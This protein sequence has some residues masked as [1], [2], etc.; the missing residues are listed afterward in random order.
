MQ[1][2]KGKKSS[3]DNIY[4]KLG[5]MGQGF[6]S[7]PPSVFPVPPSPRQGTPTSGRKQQQNGLLQTLSKVEQQSEKRAY[8][9]I[10]LRTLVLRLEKEREDALATAKHVKEE[11]AELRE[12]L[13]HVQSELAILHKEQ[14]RMRVNGW[15]D[16]ASGLSTVRAAAA[17][18]AGGGGEGLASAN[19]PSAAAPADAEKEEEGT[20]VHAA[21]AGG[22][23]VQLTKT[24]SL[25]TEGALEALNSAPPAAAAAGGVSIPPSPAGAI[26]ASPQ[27][28][29]SVAGAASEAGLVSG[30]SSPKLGTQNSKGAAAIKSEAEHSVKTH[31]LD[32]DVD[33]LQQ[34]VRQLQAEL[35]Q[36]KAVQQQAIRDKAAAESR[37]KELRLELEGLENE[38]IAAAATSS[39]TLGRS[40]TGPSGARNAPSIS[41]MAFLH[42]SDTEALEKLREDM[43]KMVEDKDSV[44]QLRQVEID[45]LKYQHTL[46]NKEKD[47]HLQKLLGDNDGLRRKAQEMELKVEQL[48]KQITELQSVADRAVA[49]AAKAKAKLSSTEQQGSGFAGGKGYKSSG[50][51]EKMASAAA[52]ALGNDDITAAAAAAIVQDSAPAPAPDPDGIAEDL[53]G[54]KVEL[55]EQIVRQSQ[56][57]QE[58]L[59]QQH[60]EEI[61]KLTADLESAGNGKV[62]ATKAAE[63][64]QAQIASMETGSAELK[65]RIQ[66]LQ[67]LLEEA[68]KER[69]AAAAKVTE[70][71]GRAE[72][73]A[74]SASA[75]AAVLE[76]R[77]SESAGQVQELQY[78]LEASEDRIKSLE[79]QL[80]DKAIQIRSS[81]DP[82]L[83]LHAEDV[84]TSDPRPENSN[85]SPESL[86]VIPEAPPLIS[87]AFPDTA[88]TPQE[89]TEDPPPEAVPDSTQEPPG[90]TSA[91]P[92]EDKVS[93]DELQVQILALTTQVASLKEALSQAEAAASSAHAEAA[94]AISAKSG[95]QASLEASMA[96]AE[97]AQAAAG[98]VAVKVEEAESKLAAAVLAAE[99]AAVKAAEEKAA[100]DA[101]AVQATEDAEL[102]LLEL[103]QS[104]EALEKL[105]MELSAQVA[106]FDLLTLQV[107]ELRAENNLL[108]EQSESVA[109][110]WRKKLE[111]AAAEA[112]LE[113]EILAKKEAEL[114]DSNENLDLLRTMYANKTEELEEVKLQ[115][116]SRS[117][118][119]AIVKEE[120]ARLAVQLSAL[121]MVHTE[122]ELQQ[123]QHTAA[124][125]GAEGKLR[126]LEQ[127][128]LATVAAAAA[129]L[130]EAHAE[131]ERLEQNL[132]L[133]ENLRQAAEERIRV[134]SDR[135]KAEAE[136]ARKAAAKELKSVKDMAAQEARHAA[137]SFE[138]LS[139]QNKK[140]KALIKTMASQLETQQ[141]TMAAQAAA[142]AKHVEALGEARHQTLDMERKWKDSDKLL[143]DRLED[144]ERKLTGYRLRLSSQQKE[145]TARSASTPSQMGSRGEMQRVFRKL[146]IIT[147]MYNLNVGPTLAS[148]MTSD[149]ANSATEL[150]MWQAVHA[151]M[152]ALESQAAAAG[153]GSTWAG[154]YSVVS[155]SRPTT[156][157]SNIRPFS[158]PSPG[159]SLMGSPVS[160]PAAVAESSG[161]GNINAWASTSPLSS[162][163]DVKLLPPPFVTSHKPP[164]VATDYQAS[165]PAPAAAAAQQSPRGNVSA[166]R[167][168]QP[169]RG[170]SEAGSDAMSLLAGH[171]TTKSTTSNHLTSS[172]RADA[173]SRPVSAAVS[174]TDPLCMS[175]ELLSTHDES[176]THAAGAPSRTPSMQVSS[177]PPETTYNM[178]PSDTEPSG[179]IAKTPL[180]LTPL[181][182][183]A[184]SN[185]P[186]LKA[187]VCAVEE[188]EVPAPV[189]EAVVPA[190][191]EEAEVPAAVEEAEVPAPVEKGSPPTAFSYN[192]PDLQ[193][194]A[195]APQLEVKLSSAEV[196][197]PQLEV[198]LSSA[199]ITEDGDS[200]ATT[201]MAS[202]KESVVEDTQVS[203]AVEASVII[204]E[205]GLEVGSGPRGTEVLRTTTDM[206]GGNVHRV[207]DD[208]TPGGEG[209]A[210]MPVEAFLEQNLEAPTASDPATVARL[211]SAAPS[212]C[213]VSHLLPDIQEEELGADTEKESSP[214]T[215]IA[216]D[217]LENDGRGESTPNVQEAAV[218]ASE[219]DEASSLLQQAR[220]HNSADNV[221]GAGEIVGSS[222]GSN[223]KSATPD[224]A[225]AVADTMTLQDSSQSGNDSSR[226]H[227]LQDELSHKLPVMGMTSRP[228]SAVHQDRVVAVAGSRPSSAKLQSRP[229]SARGLVPS[230]S[231]ARREGELPAASVVVPSIPSEGLGQG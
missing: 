126:L 75:A 231:L 115:L 54:R 63:A 106:Q 49:A 175:D 24:A 92:L 64:F 97:A 72:A 213:V 11:N 183:I 129:K 128:R 6:P 201:E 221:A 203:G 224:V 164:K 225:E 16:N 181:S 153:A 34:A 93:M 177:Y 42:P 81:A 21:G 185:I 7:M 200:Q 47:E 218:N 73:V 154:S 18:S 38:K 219:S 50:K 136:R 87:G 111:D 170:S 147:M 151:V 40:K 45:H 130:A 96:G 56:E 211:Q 204:Q 139:L 186:G 156:S 198:K 137:E 95:L 202:V 174:S 113:A 195:P 66:E 107:A 135:V 215:T 190:L 14:T 159:R 167:L 26:P 15:L 134:Y 61:R 104:K 199:D 223:K 131:N 222:D 37:S 108:K 149:S 100:A 85:A 33:Q 89:V 194:E 226:P 79:Q 53:V 67:K 35:A 171:S 12:E 5:G 197:A 150:Q 59:K 148:K 78:Q 207:D 36:A 84:I 19:E 178:L 179:I 8:E 187:A 121:N 80:A 83:A 98:S 205:G 133:S 3:N 41:G 165:T 220:D 196:P 191:V 112:A 158:P 70:G 77:L 227:K 146:K 143:R 172:F 94:A 110:E 210:I 46:A 57:E 68:E 32:A 209:K 22:S 103:A 169:G 176:F 118:E 188:A 27:I 48:G 55:L 120:R 152:T 25:L 117:E 86:Q 74:A 101:A 180:D 116:L 91:T 216:E 160:S 122:L 217:G 157:Q 102:L 189:V 1:R 39:L 76:A 163:D 132:K 2:G 144:L 206:D 105:R 173:T 182:S 168:Q 4:S 109:S 193:S 124:A 127:Q 9:L 140:M 28:P 20:A 208:S 212:V 52:A 10:N 123:E 88:E 90:D 60:A 228:G 23:N 142:A 162:S 13:T 138:A 58:K 184:I 114:E 44:I 69:A 31:L 62:D 192:S 155:S 99:V 71:E 230:L 43:A 125:Q 30:V 82:L 161:K 51:S 29:S 166:P 214:G 229:G 65:A 145:A 141:V 17:A 119:V